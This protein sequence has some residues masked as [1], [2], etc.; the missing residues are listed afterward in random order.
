M[1]PPPAVLDSWLAQAMAIIADR[2]ASPSLRHAAW[3]V[4]FQWG[5][6]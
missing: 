1:T 2:S 6:R 5:T 4:L 3:R